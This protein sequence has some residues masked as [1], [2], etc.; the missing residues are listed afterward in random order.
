MAHSKFTLHKYIKLDDGAWRYKRA[1]FYA[2]GKIKPNV[3]LVGKNAQG[4][5]IEETHAEG[6]YVMNHNGSWLDAGTDA[7][8]AQRRRNALLDQEEFKRLRGAPSA[9]SPT[10]QPTFD[11]ITL[12]AAAEKYF[13]SCEKRELDSKTIRKYR[14]AVDPFVEHCGVTYVDECREN[15]QPLLDYMGWLRKQPV[16]KRKHGNPERTFANKVEDVRIF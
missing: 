5:P 8:E 15:K 1:A 3:V 13:S 10:T 16:P 6:K 7:L 11:R 14:A 2:N 12:A 4:K 9:P